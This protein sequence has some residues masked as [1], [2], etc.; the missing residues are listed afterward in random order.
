MRC[1]FDTA[2]HKRGFLFA[3]IG[4]PIG[5][6]GLVQLFAYHAGS[7][8][9]SVWSFGVLILLATALP[10]VALGWMVCSVAAYTIAPGKLIEHRVLRDREYAFGSHPDIHQRPNGD[11]VVK[12]PERTLRIRVTKSAQCLALLRAQANR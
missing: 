5:Y 2:L 3:V 9:I 4:P 10:L 11:I 12:L 7:E 1:T 6:W 8:V